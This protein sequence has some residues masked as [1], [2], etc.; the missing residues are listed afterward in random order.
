MVII[1]QS[2]HRKSKFFINNQD[3]NF[4]MVT[5]MIILV[6]FIFI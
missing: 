3:T 6:I 5:L 2:F 4:D 1:Y